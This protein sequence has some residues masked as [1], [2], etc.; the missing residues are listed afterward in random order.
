M[1]CSIEIKINFKTPSS[2]MYSIWV[3]QHPQRK[4]MTS[5]NEIRS[6]LIS[7][8][9]I[10]WVANLI[11]CKC[12]SDSGPDDCTNSFVGDTIT[13]T[14]HEAEYI[15]SAHDFAHFLFS[16]RRRSKIITLF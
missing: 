14:F 5:F 16:C 4:Q 10:R 2:V 11:G 1:S 15:S 9:K 8:E 7:G 6:A 12:P 13:G 3:K